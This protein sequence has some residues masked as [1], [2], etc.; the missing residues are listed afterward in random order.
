MNDSSGD[1]TEYQTDGKTDTDALLLESN[2]P[3]ANGIIV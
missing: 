1:M 3:R 2:D